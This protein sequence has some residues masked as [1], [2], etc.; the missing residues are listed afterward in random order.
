[1]FNTNE[2][3]THMKAYLDIDIGSKE[4]FETDLR[5]LSI[6]KD[7]FQQVGPQVSHGGLQLLCPTTE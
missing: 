6:S 7:F 1:M 3:A 5:N 2:W 4:A